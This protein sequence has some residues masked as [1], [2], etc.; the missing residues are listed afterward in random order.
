MIV[1][2]NVLGIKWIM[3]DGNDICCIFIL[4]IKWIMNDG[5]NKWIRKKMNW[6]NK[7]MFF[8]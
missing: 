5:D 6:E 8:L 3:N 7:F 2:I 1:K 4:G